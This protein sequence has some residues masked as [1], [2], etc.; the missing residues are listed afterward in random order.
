M[1]YSYDRRAKMASREVRI[2]IDRDPTNTVRAKYH[3]QS[4][5]IGTFESSVALYRIFDGEEL[6]RVAKLGKFTGGSYSV[7]GERSHGASW[8]EDISEVIRWGNG[9]RGQRLGD[10]LFLSKIDVLDKRFYHMDPQVEFNPEGDKE[11][12]AT[13]DLSRCSTGLGCSI[14]DVSFNDATFYRVDMTGKI[15]PITDAEIHEYAKRPRKDVELHKVSQ[16]YYTG[17]ILRH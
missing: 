12:N 17:T 15:E 3:H 9:Q 11:Q 16:V 8:G 4:A 6:S 5:I 10:D 1:P 13:M 2:L 7:L 14:M